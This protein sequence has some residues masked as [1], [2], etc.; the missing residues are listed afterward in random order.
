MIKQFL[1]NEDKLP[2][3]LPVIFSNEI[4]DKIQDIRFY[5]QFDK[6]GLSRLF[7]YIKSVENHISNRSIAFSYGSD[8]T[9]DSNETIYVHDYGVIFC[10]VDYSDTI[11]VKVVWMDL[12]PKDFGLNENRHIDK[13]ITEVINQNTTNEF[14]SVSDFV[15]KG[16]E[17][18]NVGGGDSFAYFPCDIYGTPKLY[19]G[20][21]HYSCAGSA[22]EDILH[23]FGSCS[24]D[25]FNDYEFDS[26]VEELWLDCCSERGRVYFEK[27][28]VVGEDGHIP[29][30]EYV[31]KV[32][33]YMGGSPKDYSVLYNESNT[34]KE[35][36]ADLFLKSGISGK[37]K[38]T[39]LPV[40]KKLKEAYERVVNRRY[41]ADKKFP[42]NMTRAEYYWLTRQESR[43]INKI[44]IETINQYLKQNLILN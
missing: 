4:I 44:V 19:Y 35:I 13:I 40:P 2:P 11:Y 26:I 30:S 33:E 9:M 31:S 22:C 5:N 34:V 12:N 23:S 29:S 38:P 17:L 18:Y 10:L 25:W 7:S 27:Y 39:K 16:K 20:D 3:K 24:Y 32:I 21:C 28:I 6:E 1:L 41:A 37:K 14:V 42:S 36:S 8:Y 15:Y 43:K